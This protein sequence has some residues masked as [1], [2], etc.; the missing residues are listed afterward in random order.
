MMLFGEYNEMLALAASSILAGRIAE[1][2][3]FDSILREMR[4]DP[5]EIDR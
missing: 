2:D 5:F 1:M 4:A 3:R